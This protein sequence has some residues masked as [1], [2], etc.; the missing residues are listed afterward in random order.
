[1]KILG[2]DIGS[3]S[4]KIAELDTTGKGYVLSNFFE[5][6][7][8]VDPNKDRGIEIIEKLR[9]V[10]SRYD[11]GTT[12]WVIGVPQHKVSVH[13][14]RFPFRERQKI[15]KSLPFE[16][17]D[18]IPLDIDDVIFDAKIIEYIGQNTETITVTTPKETVKETL[19]LSK[20]CGFDPEI[21]SVE[22]LAL[23]NMF[24]HWSASP[25]EV[26][27]TLRE[28][29]ESG[30]IPASGSRLILHMGHRRTLLLVYRDGG[31]VA[32]RSL[33]WGGTDIAESLA[34]EFNVSYFEAL[35]TLQTNSFILMNSAGATRDQIRLSQAISNSVDVLLSELRL[36]LLEVKAGYQLEFDSMDLLGG[37]SP[38]QNLGAYLTAGLEIPVNVGQS[39]LSSSQSKVPLTPQ[40]ELTAAL[41]VGLAIEGLKRPR[42][43]AINLRKHE[44]ARENA[45]FKAF[46]EAW[47]V[48]AQIALAAFVIFFVYSVA[49]DQLSGVLLERADERLSEAA[50]QAASLKGASATDSG[51]RR[52]VNAQ[53]AT[54]RG[55]Q[56]FSQIED[57]IPALEI[58]S[59]I[60]EKFP[61]E[62][63]P[64]AGRGIDVSYFKVDNDDVHI[65]GRAQSAQ[66]LK[67]IERA[68]NE[69][70][71]A[72]SVEKVN[73]TQ[74]GTG[75][76]AAFAFKFKVN[77]KP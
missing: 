70:A 76:G 25:P 50:Q 15:L 77:R 59:K 44:F 54:I 71:K 10:A 37:I 28:A 55:R 1:V 12:K 27:P 66:T 64:T 72:K 47:R 34:R 38:I 13:Q 73:P 4:I 68:L 58:L 61:V 45:S 14:K 49:R 40:M 63:R 22:A 16:L 33:L 60:S 57:Y 41:A 46:I 30:K 48:P 9:E 36:I 23:A 42:N 53:K 35:K 43:P 29:N 6:N 31:L 56:A 17:E 5:L 18:D 65:E 75:P 74:A 24:E 21:V 62:T 39:I 67:G 20:D 32:M 26:D 69:L 52:H 8:S 51:V 11:A 19:A 2:V 3:F 7:L